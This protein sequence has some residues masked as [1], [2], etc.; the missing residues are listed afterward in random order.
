MRVTLIAHT[1]VAVG[2][3]ELSERLDWKP[4][5]SSGGE[6][7]IEFAGRACYQSWHKP[8]PKTADTAAYIA[9]VLRQRHFS[10][11]EHASVSFY[12]EDIDRSV[13]HELVRHRH[14]SFS[15]LSQRY[16]DMSGDDVEPYVHPMIRGNQELEDLL[17]VGFETAVSYYGMMYDALEK[18][19]PESGTK[20]WREAAR[21]L[22][23]NCTPTSMVVTGN[24]RSWLEFVEK[25]CS[26]AADAA[27]QE[28]SFAILRQLVELYPSV[29][30]VPSTTGSEQGGIQ[31]EYV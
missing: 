8:N 21:A 6:A 29:F 16:V 2:F 1:R 26:P 28:M 20:K 10:V 5:S 19:H 9:N 27:I 24:L 14:F 18:A 7:L 22:L 30:S 12:V 11:V 3:D 17:F 15:Q 13:S 4:T 31:P 23:P 25:R